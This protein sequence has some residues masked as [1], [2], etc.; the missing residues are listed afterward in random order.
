MVEGKLGPAS[1]GPFFC[2]ADWRGCG[3][4]SVLSA[5]SARS[6]WLNR[7]ARLPVP[8]L[9]S[10]RGRDLHRLAR[11]AMLDGAGGVQLGMV[12]D[13]P[14]DVFSKITPTQAPERLS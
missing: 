4:C 9:F 12:P 13:L 3:A 10:L 8:W 11:L 7:G 14:C 6:V 2:S 5:A 1:A